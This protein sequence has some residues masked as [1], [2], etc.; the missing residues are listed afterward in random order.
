MHL[1]SLRLRGFKSFPDAL[2]LT[3][4]PGVS[5]VVGPNG[6][7][8]SNVADAIVWAAGS[9]TPSELRADRP[10]DVLFNGAEG[11]KPAESCEVEL[12]FDNADGGFGQEL[13][14]SEVSIARR[15]HRGGEGQYLVNRAHVRRTD[16]VELLAD[17][18]LSGTMHSIV[19]QG[20]V[21]AVLATKPE[22][23]RELVEEAAGLGKFKRR[24]HRAELKLNRVGIQVERALDVEAE[25]RKR[26]RPLALQASAA[27]R[28]EKLLAEIGGLRARVADLDLAAAEA[29]RAEAE[30]RKTASGIARR[31]AQARLQ[32][33]LAERQEAEDELADAAGRREAALKAMYRLQSV[34]ERLTLRREGATG[35]LER[36]RADVAGAQA[37]A[38]ELTDE[39]LRAHELAAAEATARARAAAVASGAGAE[40]AR[41]AQERL[42]ALERVAAGRAEERLSALATERRGLEAELGDVGGSREAVTAARYRLGSAR[43]R[44]ALRRESSATLRERLRVELAEAEMRARRPGPTPEELELAANVATA[45]ARADSHARDDLASRA[46]S[47]TERLAVLES[48]LAEREGIPPAA[49]TLADAETPLALSLLDVAAGSERSVA[50]ALGWRASALVAGD[51]AA[52]LELLRQARDAGL[53]SLAVL[54][55]RSPADRVADLPV[56][57]LTEMLASRVPAVTA[58]GFGFDPDRGEL[59]FAGETAEAVLLAL[60]ARRRELEAEIAELVRAAAEAGSG[61]ET[62]RRKAEDA[63]AAYAKVAHLRSARSLDPILLR[64][65]STDAERLDEAL[66]GAVAV[67]AR[68]E[69]P[70][71]SR[72]DTAAERA[73]RLG[74][75]LAR[76]G[77]LEEQA[78]RE[79]AQANERGAAAELVR[80]RLGGAGQIRLLEVSEDDRAEVEREARELTQEAERLAAEAADASELARSASASAADTGARRT[81][82]L[83][84]DLLGRVLAGAERLDETLAVAATTAARFHAPLRAR[85]DAGATRAG[86]LGGRLRELGAAEVELRQAVEDAAQRATEIEIELTR[87]E[88]DAV[89]ARRRRD[90]SDADPAEGENRA[91]L[92]ARV[93]RLD[94]RRIQLGQ[95]NPLAKEEYALEQERLAELEAQRADLEASLKELED[96][97]AD[98]AA[99]VERRFTETFAGVAAHFEEVSETLFPGGGGR[100]RLVEPEEEGGELG[101]EV[102]LRPAGKK[103]TRLGMLSGGEKALGAISFLFALFLAKPC[104]F[105]LLDEVEAALDDANIGRFVELLRRYADRAQFVVITH[106][107]RTMEAAD[108]LY[109]VTMGG[110]GISQV[111]S[112]RLPREDASALSA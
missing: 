14:F 103:I 12:V 99:T 46:A 10:D 18:G 111:V 95:V 22:E 72:A 29:R 41:V 87:I 91:E 108:V 88:A 31:T 30:E 81:P 69:E 64:R 74:T 37:A 70:L 92:V 21:E 13:D 101:V 50:A 24:K 56:V 85:V 32:A 54:V 107:K 2:E 57:A 106:Q 15:L 23:R 104:P 45:A 43:E 68:L 33:L 75:E 78:R 11:R 105:Y 110:D 48:S 16:L 27:E 82:S 100:L 86:D 25:V 6:S 28:A 83:D 77:A 4:E 3:L 96:L 39:T 42:A 44:I 40:R 36:L 1:R 19:S 38:T 34:T 53:G 97:R 102:E 55:G 73:G 8:K 67:A 49:R 63:E 5:V 93:E 98:L 65:L 26:L 60:E 47:A 79:A 66:L 90:E 20:K 84:P 59:W 112:R 17:V 80:A 76:V 58:E 89:D 35:L 9:L 51:P 61:A 109:G 71:C 94:A 52:G 7:G 62:S